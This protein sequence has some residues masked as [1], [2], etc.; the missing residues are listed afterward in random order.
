MP[1]MLRSRI[2]KSYGAPSSAARLI[3]ARALSASSASSGVTPH[4][5][6]CW[7]RMSRLVALSSTTIA[8]K[9]PN[10]GTAGAA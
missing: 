7:R 5:A 2:A 1:G 6:S 3:L 4:D 10:S 8:R 9:D